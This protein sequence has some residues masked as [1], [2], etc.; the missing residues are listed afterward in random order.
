[1]NVVAG[2]QIRMASSASRQ[3]SIASLRKM[4]NCDFLMDRFQ[5]LVT[6]PRMPLLSRG[7]FAQ[8][9]MKLGGYVKSGLAVGYIK[10]FDTA[11]SPSGFI[12]PSERMFIEF[13]AGLGAGNVPEEV[14][15]PGLAAQIKKSCMPVRDMFDTPL[16]G[17]VAAIEKS[18]MMQARRVQINTDSKDMAFAQVTFRF[19]ASGK[20]VTEEG[21][22]KSGLKNPSLG[23]WLN[24]KTAQTPK[25]AHWN[26]AFCSQGEYYFNSVTQL[27]TWQRPMNFLISKALF[28]PANGTLGEFG[29]VLS[30]PDEAGYF[31]AEYIVTFEKP[32]FNVSVPWR[33][34]HF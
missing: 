13:M 18:E 2:R 1:M 32:M 8:Q 34:A 5:P 19:L 28:V 27:T 7:W 4:Q 22:K 26:L 29:R 24:A 14:C 3:P 16:L 23:N 6:S 10:R 15:T 31:T 11:F 9:R 12:A 20:V 25:N 17:V 30:P 21:F 33:I